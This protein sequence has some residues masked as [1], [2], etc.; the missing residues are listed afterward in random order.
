[1][2][3]RPALVRVCVLLFALSIP[4]TAQES[5]LERLKEPAVAAALKL[6]DAQ[7]ATVTQVLAAR[8]EAVKSAGDAAA[9]QAATT[10][11]NTKLSALLQPRQTQ[12][13]NSLFSGTRIRF[14]FKAQKWADVLDYI[15]TEAD[16]ALV[17]NEA[18]AGVFNY[19]DSKEYT[20]VSY[21]HLTLPTKA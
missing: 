11:A 8:D 3:C 18:P 12:L 10:S 5:N 9:K 2:T 6:T 19:S 16:L 13:F 7:Q 15:A 4:A 1:M 21:T 17:M 14:N 20:P